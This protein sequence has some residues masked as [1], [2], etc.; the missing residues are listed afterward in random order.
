MGPASDP[1]AVVGADGQVHGIEGL[2][3]ADASIMP[4]VIS[5]NTNVPTVVIGEKIGRLLAAQ[6]NEPR[7]ASA[8]P[9][10]R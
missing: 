2:Y 1:L 8:P 4:A 3:V 6:A 9:S 7:Q 5:G 10:T